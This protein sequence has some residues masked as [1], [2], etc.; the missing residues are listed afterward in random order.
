M[1]DSCRR[2]HG[3]GNWERALGS[4]QKGTFSD[5]CREEKVGERLNGWVHQKIL[6]WYRVM[7]ESESLN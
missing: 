2:I 7:M 3:M 6:P 4:D 1:V 5:G